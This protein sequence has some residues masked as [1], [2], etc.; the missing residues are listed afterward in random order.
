MQQPNTS[1]VMRP[2]NFDEIERSGSN[3][4][5]LSAA[6]KG[7]EQR[8]YSTAG[9]VPKLSAQRMN[10]LN[11]TERSGLDALLS[12]TGN[13]PDV[14][15]EETARLSRV[16][17]GPQQFRKRQVA[18]PRLYGPQVHA[19]HDEG[20]AEGQGQQEEAGGQEEG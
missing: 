10:S 3:L 18:A 14:Y 1:A 8:G 5:G 20:Q 6:F 19:G 11:A 12:A 17:E 2:L 15:K 4:P 7:E 9:G 13:S 16:G